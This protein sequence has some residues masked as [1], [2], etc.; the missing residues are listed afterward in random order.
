QIVREHLT[1]VD[2]VVGDHHDEAV[3]GKETG[4]LGRITH[5]DV[6]S[7]GSA[8]RNAGDDYAVFVHV[9]CTLDRVGNCGEVQHLIFTPP[10]GRIPRVGNHVNL[11]DALKGRLARPT[12]LIALA[13]ANA[14]MQLKSDLVS[15]ARIVI[16]GNV[17]GIKV[18]DSI[19]RLIAQ[20]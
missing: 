18:F 4:V 8:V 14:A 17:Q 1:V 19:F 11:F 3:E 9:V 7:A 12:R 16:R 15:A 13:P 6:I 5:S 10:R 2:A 20:L